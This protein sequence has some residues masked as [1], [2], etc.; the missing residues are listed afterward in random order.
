MAYARRRQ[1]QAFA[2]D[3]IAGGSFDVPSNM[4][5]TQRKMLQAG[6]VID[7]AEQSAKTI[8]AD[9]DNEG[10]LHHQRMLV[11]KMSEEQNLFEDSLAELE[12][13]SRAQPIELSKE[14]RE[15]DNAARAGDMLAMQENNV[16]LGEHFDSLHKVANDKAELLASLRQQL[17]E[18]SGEVERG[19][20]AGR[21]SNSRVHTM[22]QMQTTIEAAADMQDF[23]RDTLIHM[24]DRTSSELHE[25]RKHSDSVRRQ[26]EQLGQECN[27][28]LQA[29]GVIADLESRMTS[30]ARRLK[31]S[32]ER[33]RQG[34]STQLAAR[35]QLLKRREGE[36]QAR[37]ACKAKNQQ[38][39]SE[40]TNRLK[41]LKRKTDVHGQIEGLLSQRVARDLGGHADRSMRKLANGLNLPVDQVGADP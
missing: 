39:V 4:N 41:V 11:A 12:W 32:L 37:L 34:R 14:N 10:Y 29:Q 24:R 31:D 25:F 21:Y 33:E 18:T 9:H 19:E 17:G 8:I 28:L 6:F 20:V 1:I 35:K 5:A 38:R 22:Q 36:E 40:E 13:R 26:A 3:I 16:A 15:L 27:R 23:E 30:G 2:T 7:T